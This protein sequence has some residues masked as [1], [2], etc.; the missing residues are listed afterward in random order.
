[1]SDRIILRYSACFKQQ[2]IRELAEGRNEELP[3]LNSLDLSK[4]DLQFPFHPL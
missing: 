2:V 3:G 4:T 1:M